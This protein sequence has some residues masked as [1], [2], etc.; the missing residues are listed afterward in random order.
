VLR[1]NAIVGREIKYI[2]TGGLGEKLHPD[3]ITG[4]IAASP[5]VITQVITPSSSRYRAGK[6]ND[7]VTASW[8][9]PSEAYGMHY[10][11]G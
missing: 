11:A 5:E 2:I 8:K 10:N 7:V 4:G 6:L 1:Y 3:V 9:L